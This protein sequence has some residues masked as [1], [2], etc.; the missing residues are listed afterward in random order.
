MRSFLS[1]VLLGLV[2]GASASSLQS[3]SPTPNALDTR[4]VVDVCANLDLD[5]K[6]N[7]L[8][9]VI[10]IGK[11]DVC[12]CISGIDSFCGSNP[13]A[14]SGVAL[15]GKSSMTQQLTDLVNQNAPKAKCIYPEHAIP[16]CIG[17]NPCGF[18]CSDGFVPSPPSNPKECICPPPFVVCNGICTKEKVCPSGKPHLKREKR[19][20]GSGECNARGGGHM[21]CGVFGGAAR[22]WE[23]ID[24]AKDLESCGGCVFPLTPYTPVGV[25]CTAVPGVAD[26]SCMDSSCVVH[27]CVAGYTRSAD[28]THCIANGSKKTL[29]IPAAEYGLEHVPLGH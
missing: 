16:E 10:I 7:L 13:V 26:V 2:A 8:G 24:T 28:S 25:D 18:S 20:V 19:W 29:E 14:Q 5:L 3:R 15:V 21:A 1:F 6:I 27:R 12:L 11:L 4:D 23:C 22:A 9:I 17:K